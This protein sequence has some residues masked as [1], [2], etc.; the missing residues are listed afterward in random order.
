M[1]KIYPIIAVLLLLG[2]ASRS[3]AHYMWL[4]RDG[5]GPVR[6]YYGEWVDD[7]REKTGGLLDRFK[8]P[9]VFLGASSEP[10][11]VKRNENNLEFAAMGAGD[12]RLLESGISTRDDS[13]KGGKTKTI[14]YA[15]H[16]RSET[17]AKLDLELVPAEANG[18]TFLLIYFGAPLPKAELTIIGPSKWEKPLT[19]DERGRVTLPMPWLGRY[20]LEVIYF[21]EKA[22]GSG[23]EKFNR[24][25]HISTISFFQPDGM[26]WK[27][28]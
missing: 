2:F 7:I 24:T 8:T 6:A 21:D 17:T 1:L 22:G 3:L 13:E 14:Y 10:L 26:I 11:P 4:E 19:T 18:K 20:V 27:Q 9:R 5:E 15:K 23:E 16:G 12:V 25:R 28:E